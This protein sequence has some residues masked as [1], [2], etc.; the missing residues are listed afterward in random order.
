MSD[1]KMMVCLLTSSKLIY[2]KESYK[3]VLNQF[4]VKFKYDIFI[5][6]NTLNE[7]Y[8]KSV[9]KEFPNANI[10][11]TESNGKPGKGHNSVL[12]FFKSKKEYN[13]L[14]M[15]DGDDF[16][17]PSALSHMEAYINSTNVDILMLMC[18]DILSQKLGTL[19]MS[20]I[21]I[22]NK[23]YLIYNISQVTMSIWFKG[24]SINPFKNNIND[25]NT[26]GRLILF[27]RKSLEY[28]IKYDEECSLYD[29]YYP[30]M[31]VMELAYKKLNVFRT[32]D[33]NIYL[34]NSLNDMSQTNNYTKEKKE[35]ENEI[36]QK[37]IKDKFLDIRDWDLNRINYKTINFDPNFTSKEKYYFVKSLVSNLNINN[38]MIEEKKNYEIF[39]KY[40]THH[41]LSNFYFFVEYYKN[42]K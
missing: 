5:I 25:L 15:L 35:K 11:R 18:H 33:S 16:L 9:I 41:K 19:N 32:D 20:N 24:K 14:F 12:N 21:M 2:L 10:V 39:I 29:D 40:L 28:N 27:S 22:D 8:Y 37:S 13:Y 4:P 23:A 34:Y 36:F 30:S 1:I 3:S 7:D 26:I 42:I 6:V 17:Y 38:Y 31:Q